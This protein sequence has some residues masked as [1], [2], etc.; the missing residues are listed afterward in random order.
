MEHALSPTVSVNLAEFGLEKTEDGQHVQWASGSALHP[1]HWSGARKF[2]DMTLILLLEAFTC[3]TAARASQHGTDHS[4]TLLIFAYMSSYQLGQGVGIIVFPPYSEAFGR[5]K[6][7]IASSLLYAVFCV[8]V[9]VGNSHVASGI[10]RFMTGVLSA[11]PSVVITGSIADMFKARTR[12]WMVFLY[13]VA[14]G[15][16]LG[17]GPVYSAYIAAEYGWEWVFYIAA[18]VTALLAVMMLCIRESRP[19][20][21]LRQHAERLQRKTGQEFKPFIPDHVPDLKTFARI[22]LFRPAQLLF[23]EPVMFTLSVISGVANGLFYLFVDTVPDIYRKM[24]FSEQS[25]SLPLLTIVIAL[26]GN[27]LIRCYDHRTTAIAEKQTHNLPPEHKLFGMWFAAP[28]LTIGLWIFAWTI[29]PSV[30]AVHWAVSSFALCLVGFG[31]NEFSTVLSSYVTDVYLNHAASA[32]AALSFLRVTFGAFFPLFAP[33]MFDDL[34]AN[35]AV[36]VLAI[37]S[38]FICLVPPVFHLYGRQL[39]EKSKFS[40]YSTTAV[41]DSS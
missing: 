32:N 6:L 11:I 39:R 37:F 26:V 21:L 9:G 17:L 5:K 25:S 13:I 16:G 12:V 38:T 30:P 8:I 35:K 1:W 19:S 28:G 20:L 7:Y 23:S 27:L 33:R 3:A 14:T 36:S 2:Y 34:G 22:S 15:T 41:S 18:M 24:G 31:L 4:M 29:P 10:A 40:Q